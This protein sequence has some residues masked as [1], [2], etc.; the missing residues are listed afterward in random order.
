MILKF[1]EEFV[2]RQYFGVFPTLYNTLHPWKTLLE[3]TAT[4]LEPKQILKREHAFE[5]KF[6]DQIL[7]LVSFQ[8]HST[9][10]VYETLHL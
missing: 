5:I 2:I 1:K 10:F 8:C 4:A 7:I 9:F 3:A 6:C